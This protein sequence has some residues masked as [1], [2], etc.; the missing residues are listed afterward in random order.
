MK[1]L[2]KKTFPISFAITLAEAF[3]AQRGKR[4]MTIEEALNNK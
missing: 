2:F 1:V 3:K 4:V